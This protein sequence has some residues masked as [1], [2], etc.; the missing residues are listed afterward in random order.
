MSTGK[1]FMPKY[2]LLKELAPRD[3]VSRSILEEMKKTN[4]DHVYLNLSPIGAEKIPKRF[5]KIYEECLKYGIDI[6][7]GQD[8]GDA[9]SALFHGRNKDRY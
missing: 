8:T 2:H 4:S 9:G 1:A 6:Y 5:P 3:I 7:K